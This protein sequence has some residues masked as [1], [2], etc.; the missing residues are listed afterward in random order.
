MATI[1]SSVFY[2]TLGLSDNASLTDVD[3]R[4]LELTSFLSGPKNR[5]NQEDA[6]LEQEKVDKEYHT[7]LSKL[8]MSKEKIQ[9]RVTEHVTEPFT[10]RQVIN[11]E[12][13]ILMP[14]TDNKYWSIVRRLLETSDSQASD[15]RKVDWVKP[16]GFGILE[17]EG[18]IID[19]PDRAVIVHAVNCQGVWGCG[20]AAQ[21]RKQMKFPYAFGVYKDHCLRAE[22]P[23]DL[24]GTCLLIE[25]QPGD[26][27]HKM[28]RVMD[29][30]EPENSLV[31]GA[32][33]DGKRHWIACLFTSVGYG[34]PN[35]A[36]N[37]PGK[38]PQ[39]LILK[40]TRYALEELRTRLEGFGPSNLNEE[41]N[42][43]ADDMKPGELWSGK[44]NSGAF[45]VDWE[46]TRDILEDEF[47]TFERPWTV[48]R[49]FNKS[50]CESP[51]TGGNGHAQ[52]SS[53]QHSR[54]GLTR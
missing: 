49:K 44:F 32:T 30:W 21:L 37:N 5:G 24:I 46:M 16:P 52:Q 22:K 15:G 43:Q 1:D 6:K 17:I 36:A 9:E 31:S 11:A 7:I 47:E 4:Y 8:L 27:S 26:Y 10:M 2:S 29:K 14:N 13:R 12:D 39:K 51:D 18:D 54:W 3:A 35:M 38:D 23:Y 41:T 28:Q 34:R 33:V 53:R 25:P 20:M 42:W 50:D 19:A 45:G 48:I 40:H